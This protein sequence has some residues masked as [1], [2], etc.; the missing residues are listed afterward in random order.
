MENMKI[1]QVQ[2]GLLVT[3]LALALAGFFFTGALWR[4]YER[5]SVTRD[6]KPTA[7]VV[8]AAWID[9]I[10]AGDENRKAF[11]LRYSYEWGGK[12]YV[13]TRIRDLDKTSRQ[14]EGL[15]SLVTKYPVGSHHECFVN[16]K[17]PELAVLRKGSQAAAYTLWFPL[18]FV[19]GGIGIIWRAVS[20]LF[21][22]NPNR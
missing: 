9:D 10:L 22:R 4:A 6:W 11:R 7:C 3:G 17:Q 1:Q 20:P 16:P 12:S 5:A 2:W 8:S 15:Q 21:F 18:L 13:G 19:A 14:S